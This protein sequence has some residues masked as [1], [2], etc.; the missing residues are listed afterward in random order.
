MPPNHVLMPLMKA[1]EAEKG[2]D[3][4]G[5]T[6]ARVLVGRKDAK[7]GII[8]AQHYEAQMDT[9]DHRRPDTVSKRWQFTEGKGITEEGLNK[10]K[11]E[12]M[13][14]WECGLFAETRQV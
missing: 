2:Q 8:Q 1:A 4:M 5:C 10:S 14:K 12:A 11:K 7:S 3:R 13:N 6:D 9:S